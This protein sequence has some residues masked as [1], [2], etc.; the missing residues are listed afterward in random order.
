MEDRTYVKIFRKMLGW[1]WY[2]DTNTFR[3]FMHI[4]LKANYQE[5]EYRGHKIPAGSCVFGRKKWSKELGLSEQQ[6]RTAISHLQSTNEITIK[7]TNKF[8]VVTLTNWE[9][10]Q[11]EEGKSTKK[12]TNH[13]PSSQPTSNQQVTTSKENKNIRNT[14]TPTIEDVR[15]Y[16]AD[17]DLSI[18][19]D[20]F[21]K[22]YETA[23]WKDY[24]GH[25][26]KNWK[27]KALN[28][29]RKEVERNGNNPGAGDRV[30]SRISETAGRSKRDAE[31]HRHKPLPLAADVFAP[32]RSEDDA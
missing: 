21:Y 29:N 18:D 12:R 26:V 6:I 13:Q 15:K 16:V 11:I 30:R 17:N 25:P 32:Q 27:L 14:T 8:T 9:F 24:K 19:A 3:V 28:W 7:S 2:G 20:Y 5:S 4:L 31:V 22:Y 1:G 23:E 10:W